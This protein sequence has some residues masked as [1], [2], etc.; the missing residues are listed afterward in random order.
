MR[1]V[2]PELKKCS[3]QRVVAWRKNDESCE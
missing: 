3:W 2:K 1:Y